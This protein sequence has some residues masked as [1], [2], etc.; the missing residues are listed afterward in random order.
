MSVFVTSKAQA[1]RHAVYAIERTPPTSIRATGTGTAVLIGQFP[2]GPDSAT[3]VI[4]EPSSTADRNRTFAPPGMDHT[5]SAYLSTLAKA[6]PRLLCVRVLGSTAAAATANLQNVTPA[7]IVVATLKYK[8]T[9][10]NAVAWTVSNAS[11]GVADHFNLR[12]SVTS[13]S[14]TTEDFIQNLNYSGTGADSV[15]DLTKTYLLG[16][17]S[18]SLSG[19]P[20]NGSGTFSGG[21][22]GTINAAR[23]VG[24]AQ[25]GDMG[26][27]KCEGNKTIRHVFVDDPGNTDRAAVNAGLMA[28]AILMGDRTAYVNGNSG[29]SAAAT[30]TD[31]ANY[32]SD[33]VLYCDPW[34]Y[35]RDDIT[36]ALRLVPPAPWVT[37]LNSQ[38]SPSTSLAWKATEARNM[39]SGIAG[40]EFDRG[41]AAA[42]LSDAGVVVIIKE[43]NGGY[44]CESDNTTVTLADPARRKN[45]RRKMV[46]YIGLSFVDSSRGS[47]DSPNVQQNRDDLRVALDEFMSELKENAKKDANHLPHVVDYYIPPDESANDLNS[48]AA[49]EYTLPLFVQLSSDMEK[50]FLSITASEGAITVTESA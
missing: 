33:R 3:D 15:P 29:L 9:A 31:R 12:V 40:L 41:E 19:R 44:A 21:V 1:T 10:G 30:L 43:A 42:T 46:D 39:L 20:L 45:K 13:A 32:S 50:I 34:V 26:I 47:V 16:S 18:K 37:S 14:G 25:T 17:I 27:A 6:Y 7:T 23:Y 49:G 5:G 2:W 35:V 36:Q 8:G 4:Y 24:T 11:D 38:L 48:I 28:H 22:T